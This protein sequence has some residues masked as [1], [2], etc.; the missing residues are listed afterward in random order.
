M[1]KIL[2]RNHHRIIYRLLLWLIITCNLVA[3]NLSATPVNSQAAIAFSD[4]AGGAY[5]GV[6]VVLRVDS[7]PTPLQQRHSKLDDQSARRPGA[8]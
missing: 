5:E 6:K 4:V 8:G 2:E 3:L 7:A 1:S